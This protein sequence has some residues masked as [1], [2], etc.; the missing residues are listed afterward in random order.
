MWEPEGNTDR[1]IFGWCN[2]F[3]KAIS[4]MAVLGIPSSL[5]LSRIFFRATISPVHYVQ[6]MTAHRWRYRELGTRH[7]KCLTVMDQEQTEPSPTL[8]NCSYRC[9]LG[10]RQ[11]STAW[12]SDSCQSSTFSLVLLPILICKPDN[13]LPTLQQQVSHNSSYNVLLIP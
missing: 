12:L 3:S 13:L 4:R 6:Q 2:S 11:A 5:E 9:I 1:T 8:F 10:E 7:R